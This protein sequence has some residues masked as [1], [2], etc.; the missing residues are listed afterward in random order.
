MS[1]R[2]GPEAGERSAHL[3]IR[4]ALSVGVVAAVALTAALV[5]F[6]WSITSRGN[7][8]DVNAKLNAQVIRSIAQ[9]VDGLLDNAVAARQALATNIV[10]GVIDIDDQAKREFLFL[11]F[12]QSQPAL[13]VIEYGWLDN[14][15]FLARRADDGTIHMEETVPG[16]NGG[17]RRSDVYRINDDGELIFDHRDVVPSDYRV[18]EQ[19]WFQTAFDT[20]QPI[21]SNIYPMPSTG[22][23]GV[24]TTRAIQREGDLLGVLGVSISLDRLSSFLDGIE[25][26][27]GSDVFLT[28]IY[29]ELVAVQ[30]HGGNSAVPPAAIQKLAESPIPAVRVVVEA[31]R[32]DGTELRGLSEPHQLTWQDG[33]TF[34][35]TLAPLAQMGLITAVVIPESDILGSVNRNTRILLLVLI[36]FIALIGA[37]ATLLARRIIGAPLAR[38]TRNLQ[39]LEDFRLD[40]VVAIPSRFSE[41]R[42]VSAATLRMS[43]SLASFKKF[44][45]TELVRTL[46]AQGIEAELGGE[47]RELTIMFMDIAGFTRLSEQFGDRLIEF[48]GDYL[49]EMSTLIQERNGTID[50]YI[51]DAIMAFWGAPVANPNH[52]VDACRAMLAC[53][54]RLI[55]MGPANLAAGYPA[56]RARIGINTGRVLVGN[57]GS[58]DRLNYTVI[59]D[60]VNVASRLESLS[61]VYGTEIIIGE[62]TYEEARDHILVR[63]LDRVAVYG[64]ESG[65]QTY[66]LLAMKADCDPAA[67]GWIAVYD[68]ACTALR[69]RRW[70]EAIAGFERVIALRGTDSVSQVQI[71]RALQFRA[72][73]PAA[74]WDG[75]VMMESK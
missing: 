1:R 45:P 38:V 69:G 10:Q 26:S 12:L 8:A 71:K 61:K 40:R 27:R 72:N 67:F 24:T 20:E 58:R 44:I 54:A 42:Q 59:G 48:L 28:N 16:E 73:P 33:A 64:R 75:S 4:A 19:F 18:T 34:Y 43:A 35:V 21:W 74:T 68:A 3:S 7:I 66:E 30:R 70:D 49:S 11:S 55:A 37:A 50:K 53:Q 2:P 13:T 60:P 6:P 39:Q 57:F 22:T 51:G 5:H 14:H 62:R 17:T 46:F 31:L 41:I 63:A 65:L 56:L 9:K 47:R 32:Q 23:L 29:D 15:S 52:A 36:G 25:I